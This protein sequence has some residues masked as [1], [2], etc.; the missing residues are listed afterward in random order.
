MLPNLATR[1]TLYA[2][3][4][5]V[6][7]FRFTAVTFRAEVGQVNYKANRGNSYRRCEYINKLEFIEYVEKRFFNDAISVDAYPPI[8]RRKKAVTREI[9]V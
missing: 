6:A 7:Q 4:S 2:T 3:K 8:H 9:T 1:P 5:S